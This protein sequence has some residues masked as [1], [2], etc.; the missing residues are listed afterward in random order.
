MFYL[1]YTQSKGLQ[2][3]A[4]LQIIDMYGSVYNKV[5]ILGCFSN[6]P[7]SIFESSKFCDDDDDDDDDDKLYFSV[8]SSSWPCKAY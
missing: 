1:P 2:C 8:R 5:Q 7:C 3:F 6:E 4:I